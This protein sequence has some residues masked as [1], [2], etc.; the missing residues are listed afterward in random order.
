[1]CDE[2]HFVCFWSKCHKDIGAYKR[3]GPKVGGESEADQDTY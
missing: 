3:D 2:G 1:M